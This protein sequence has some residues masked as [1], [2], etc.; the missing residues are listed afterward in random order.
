M[1]ITMAVAHRAEVCQRQWPVRTN[2]HGHRQPDVHLPYLRCHDSLRDH[3]WR[4]QR[5]LPEDDRLRIW[6]FRDGAHEARLLRRRRVES[7]HPQHSWLSKTTTLP[8]TEILQFKLE[9]LHKNV[10]TNG[11]ADHPSTWLALL[12]KLVI[13]LEICYSYCGIFFREGAM[14]YQISFCWMLH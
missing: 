9:I 1:Q 10:N 2:W 13:Y 4:H 6:L 11:L 7:E 8:T 12:R 5:H 3:L 14:L